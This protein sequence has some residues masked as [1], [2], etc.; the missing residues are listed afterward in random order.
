[1]GLIERI[2]RLAPRLTRRVGAM[3]QQVATGIEP[4]L[5]RS[6]AEFRPLLDRIEA[7]ATDDAMLRNELAKIR[8]DTPETASLAG[9]DPFDP[10]YRVA[11]LDLYRK[12]FGQNHAVE[13]EGFT[14]DV[15]VAV[16][17]P[18]PWGTRSASVMG[19]FV[20]AYGFLIESL[21]LAPGARVLEL[22]SGFGSLT[23]FLARC[24]YRVVAV[25]INASDVELTRRYCAGL[26][27][28]PQAVQADINSYR[29][30]GRFDAVVFFESFHHFLEHEALLA[31][32][33]A[34]LE[35]G[36]VVALAAE[37][38]VSSLSPIVP[39]PWGP[40][41]DGESLRAMAAFG[42]MELGF[43]RDYLDALIARQGWKAAHRALPDNPWSSVFLLRPA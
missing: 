18:F 14:I 43:R 39:Y 12:L 2:S 26:D 17:A 19:R 31:R 6:V 35:P 3:A 41:L 13:R 23:W 42:W 1:M 38:I 40:R 30:D 9:L 33:R 24:G 36:G 21:D 4:T 25:D 10:S 11:V 22:G 5:V 7:E 15:D 27:P 37:P 32:C 34:W 29:P 8:L 16:R 28:E 20:A